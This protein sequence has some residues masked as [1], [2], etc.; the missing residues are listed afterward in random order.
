MV[1]LSVLSFV[2]YRAGIEN[3]RKRLIE[4]EIEGLKKEAE[5]IEKENRNLTEKIAYFETQDFREKE[6][7]EKL[8]FQKEG[9]S[10][11]VIKPSPSQAIVENEKPPVVASSESEISNGQKWWR[12][13]FGY[14]YF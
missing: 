2:A 6:A 7:K 4:K 12:Y 1:C 8:N 13:F 11:A 5:K 10:V 3:Q 9:E 14:W